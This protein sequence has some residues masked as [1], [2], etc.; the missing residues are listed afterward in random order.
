[1][2]AE[3]DLADLGIHRISMP[4]PFPEAGGPV[5]AYALADRD[6]GLVLFDAGLGSRDAEAAL[7]EGLRRIGRSPSDVRRIVVSHGHVDH[8]GGARTV[9]EGAG[10]DVPVEVHPRDLPKVAGAGARWEELAPAYGAHLRR[11]GVPA[12]TLGE[13]AREVAR[14][15]A[16]ARPVPSAR[17]LDLEEPVRLSH[18]TFEILHMPGHTPGLV[19]LY[20]REHRIF[21]SDDHLLERVSPNPLIEVGPGGEE[22]WR[23]LVAYLESVV[24]LRALEVDVVLPGHAT[25]F[26]DHRRVIDRLLHFY[27]KRQARIEELLSKGPATAWELSRALFP[28][29]PPGATFLTV[30]EAIANLEVLEARGRVAREEG[31]ALRRF[32]LA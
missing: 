29:A 31:G 13:A 25:P 22:G 26:D 23:P 30:S 11:L 9:M 4:I 28:A 20:D 3:R 12:E 7:A 21:V 5:N 10:H 27:G 16:L 6:G 19:C 17:P 8:F 14:G 18:A 32:R 1:M 2:I 15:F 24:R